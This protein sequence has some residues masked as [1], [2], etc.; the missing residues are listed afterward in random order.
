[1]ATMLRKNFGN[2][3]CQERLDAIGIA[4][5][6]NKCDGLSQFTDLALQRLTLSATLVGTPWRLPLSTS[7]FFTHSRSVC[8]TQPIFS[9]IDTTGAHLDR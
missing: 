6:I 3:E 7:A 2:S 8:G 5:I 9:A 1:M 4:V